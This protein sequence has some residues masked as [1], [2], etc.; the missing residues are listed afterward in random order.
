MTLACE[1]SGVGIPGL[2]HSPVGPEQS[3]TIVRCSQL[4]RTD[5]VSGPVRNHG[6]IF[7]C[8]LGQHVY[9]SLLFDERRSSSL[10]GVQLVHHE[11]FGVT[12]LTQ[13]LSRDVYTLNTQYLT[14]L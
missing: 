6:H 8:F 14:I 5:V 7:I 11:H 10:R 9:F 1:A 13:L 12:I 3:R 2:S 4:A